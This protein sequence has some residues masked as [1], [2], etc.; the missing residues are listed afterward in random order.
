MQAPQITA[1]TVLDLKDVLVGTSIQTFS[2][3]LSSA[4]FV[5]V[6]QNVFQNKLISGLVARVPSVNPKT[7]FLAGATNL[8]NAVD[9]K[10]ITEVISVYND[11]L[12]TAFH[13]GIAM[14]RVFIVGALAMEWK[15]AKGKKIEIGMA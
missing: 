5:F 13:A 4:L 14:P 2:Q 6:G 12:V 8:K 15:S 1:Q 11:A 9:P 7:I 10:F 3:T